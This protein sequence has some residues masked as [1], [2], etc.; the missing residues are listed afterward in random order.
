VKERLRPGAGE[1]D[2]VS[3]RALNLLMFVQLLLAGL[4]V[5]RLH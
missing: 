1:Q 2:Q 4:D 3:V 5:G